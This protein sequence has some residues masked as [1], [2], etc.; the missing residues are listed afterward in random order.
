MSPNHNVLN[1]SPDHLNPILKFQSKFVNFPS[2]SKWG[3]G[4]PIPQNL[5]FKFLGIPDFSWFDSF[6]EKGRSGEAAM[7][8]NAFK[9]CTA[10]RAL[11]YVMV[12]VVVAIVGLTYYA[13]VLVNYLPSILS[14][15]VNFVIAFPLLILFHFLVIPVSP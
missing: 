3:N 5:D 14:G 2:D 7:A 9:L 13:V 4:I 8:W 11:G 6:V 1:Q 12:L 10:L 15:G